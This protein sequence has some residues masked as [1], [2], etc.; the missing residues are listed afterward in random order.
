MHNPDLARSLNNLSICLSD[1]GHREEALEAVQECVALYRD[2]ARDRPNAFNPD[3]A[4]SLNT[5]SI[6]LSDLGHR[7]EALEAVRE[8]V[9]LSVIW[10][11]IGQMHSILTLPAH[12]TTFPLVCPT[13][14][15]GKRLLKPCRNVWHS[16]VIWHEI[17][18]MRSILTLPLA[19]HPFHLS[20]RPRSS[21]R[22][23]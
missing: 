18:Q 10:H 9:A 16:T 17:G 22:G 6:C 15:I 1:L 20:V 5:L 7:E 19:Q 3:L 13:S 8:C 4:R 23:S 14:V 2:L 12:S 11:E 21:G